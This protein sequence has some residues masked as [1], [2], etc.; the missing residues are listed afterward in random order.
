MPASIS[1][2]CCATAAPSARWCWTTTG[3][4]S[5]GCTCRRF[6]TSVSSRAAAR[7]RRSSAPVRA[8]TAAPYPAPSSSC[9]P[10]C[11]RPQA[12]SPANRYFPA[13]RPSP[14]CC[15]KFIPPSARTLSGWA[16]CGTPL[17]T[18]P[19][20][21]MAPMPPLWQMRSA[22]NGAPPCRPPPKARSGTLWRWAMWISGSSGP[23]TSLSPPR[24]PSAS[25]WSRSWPSWG[26]RPS[27]WA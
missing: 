14:G 13:C 3:K 10:R 21:A 17:P 8:G 20:P 27:C 25:C 11:T 24:S 1:I 26:C 7:W 5:W 23:I 15:C 18:V 6:P 4:S 16:T 2:A 19:P 12:R 9:S 22:G